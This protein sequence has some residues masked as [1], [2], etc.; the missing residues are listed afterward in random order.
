MPT[1]TIAARLDR[2]PLARFHFTILAM[3]A[4]SLLFDT[5]DG[6]VMTFVP[7][8]LAAER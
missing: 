3:A 2:L 4:A 5:L 7:T 6:I 1:A 8:N